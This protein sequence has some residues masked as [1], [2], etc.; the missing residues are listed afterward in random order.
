[1]CKGS[2]NFTT[3]RLYDFTIEKNILRLA[4]RI[5]NGWFNPLIFQK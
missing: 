5:N 2:V 3:L 1:M 4:D